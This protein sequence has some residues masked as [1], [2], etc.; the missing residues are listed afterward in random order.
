MSG[1]SGEDVR[2]R[3]VLNDAPISPRKVNDVL[4]GL[5]GKS[6]LR[7][8]AALNF[9]KTKSAL[10][11]RNLVLS[12][13]ANAENNHGLSSADLVVSEAFVGVRRGFRRFVARG[14]G[15][16]G[17]IEK[18]RSQITVVLSEKTS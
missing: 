9:G 18:Y 1:E 6:A 10:L 4:R 15:R 3:A 11:V 17:V 7:V 2:V 12:A 8:A 14:R 5:R 16:S 13:L